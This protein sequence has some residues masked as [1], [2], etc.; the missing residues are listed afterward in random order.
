MHAGNHTWGRF[1]KVNM[2]VLLVILSLL[3]IK[4]YFA[5]LECSF[6]LFIFFWSL[7]Q[8]FDDFFQNLQ[9]VCV[10]CWI[11][12]LYPAQAGLCICKHY[13]LKKSSKK[14]VKIKCVLICRSELGWKHES[15]DGPPVHVL[16]EYST[17]LSRLLLCHNPS[18]LDRPWMVHP[19]AQEEQGVTFDRGTM[20]T[21]CRN[22]D[23]FKKRE[24]LRLVQG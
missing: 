15:K 24:N 16:R 11:G 9:V 19:G 14:T 12:E 8:L 7:I 17:Q 20:W 1:K 5:K 18:P 2:P 3:K 6:L 22:N 23:E 10:F 13:I 4:F 21:T